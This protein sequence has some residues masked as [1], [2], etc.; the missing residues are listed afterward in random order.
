M[1]SGEDAAAG[2]WRWQQ[3]E[4]RGEAQEGRDDKTHRDPGN[5]Q[6][7]RLSATS[8]FAKCSE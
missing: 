6:T 1:V 4:E 5:A 8:L 3:G 7:K 2:G